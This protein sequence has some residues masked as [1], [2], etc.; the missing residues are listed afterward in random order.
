MNNYKIRVNNEAESKEAQELFSQLGFERAWDK[1]KLGFEPNHIF[2]KD[3]VL[4]WLHHDR[5]LF[6]E[7]ENEELTLPQLRD[8]VAQSKYK[9]REYLDPERG[10]MY[11]KLDEHEFKENMLGNEKWIEIPESA[12]MALKHHDS[13]DIFFQNTYPIGMYVT[14]PKLV[15]DRQ[16]IQKQGLIS[17]ADALR[18]LVDGEDVQG[19]L[20]LKLWANAR[21]YGL[22]EFLDPNTSF[23]FRLKPRTVKLEIEVPAPF[24]PK[25]GDYV[26]T[27]DSN[28]TDGWT[29]FLYQASMERKIIYGAWRTEAEIKIVVE[30]IRKLK[31]HSK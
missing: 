10:Y 2:S 5:I 27:I 22:D 4:T 30:Q 26:F 8:L 21:E 23:K 19:T 24:E 29:K 15:W 3:G 1:E 11:I 16:S 20:D 6:E 31:E 17:G 7:H 28:A 9:V 25:Y 18:A 13:E 12:V 14:R